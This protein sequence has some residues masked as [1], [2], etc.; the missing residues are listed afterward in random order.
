MSNGQ[1]AA[2]ATRVKQDEARSATIDV[3]DQGRLFRGAVEVDPEEGRAALKRTTADLVRLIR[4]MKKP[5][6]R[7]PQLE[8][9]S[10]E[11][12]VHLLQT[13][14]NDIGYVE[15]TVTPY[16]VMDGKVLASGAKQSARKIAEEPERDPRKLAALLDEAINQFLERTADRDP[17]Q[18][19]PFAEG[20]AMT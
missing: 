11:V 7:P 6:E 14:R 17:L 19:V 10:V 1:E 2:M 18:P 16:P 4:E 5:T 13:F 3:T 20:H 8:W 9:T 12:A 15:G